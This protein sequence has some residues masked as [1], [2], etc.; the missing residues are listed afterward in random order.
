[1]ADRLL[2]TQDRQMVERGS[3]NIAILG[4]LQAVARIFQKTSEHTQ[5]DRF[6]GMHLTMRRDRANINQAEGNNL[7]ELRTRPLFW[8]V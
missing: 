5:T 2:A 7:S 1:M 4:L 3:F 8:G 6:L